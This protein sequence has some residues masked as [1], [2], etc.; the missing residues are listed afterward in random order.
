MFFSGTRSTSFMYE[1]TVTV[2]MKQK[3][4]TRSSIALEKCEILA[5]HNY[6]MDFISSLTEW[7]CRA[8]C[9]A[10][11]HDV[12]SRSKEKSTWK[13]NENKLKQMTRVTR[14]KN[15]EKF[16][17]QLLSRK[18]VRHSK[19]YW[20]VRSNLV[21]PAIPTTMPWFRNARTLHRRWASHVSW[22]D[23]VVPRRPDIQRIGDW[24]ETCEKPRYTRDTVLERW[25]A[26]QSRTN[27]ILIGK[28]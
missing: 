5:I 26:A 13:P 28:G 21:Q 8:S 22:M 4:N 20:I 15:E 11:L 3:L 7:S 24:F 27:F 2:I 25:V 23:R 1:L 9:R 14:R 6:W 10:E 12:W 19:M 17:V 16:G 18:R